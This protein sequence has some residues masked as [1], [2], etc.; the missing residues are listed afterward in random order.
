MAAFDQDRL[1]RALNNLVQNACEALIEAAES[2]ELTGPFELGI[3][4]RVV[5]DNLEILVADSGPG[6]AQETLSRV[7][8]PLFSTKSGA[9][10]LGLPTVKQIMTQHGGDVEVTSRQ[11]GGTEVRLW[12]PIKQVQEQ[13]A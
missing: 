2:G 12:M 13:A 11:G 8:E 1:R 3:E 5:G 10:G 4:S 6:M 7:F 9:V